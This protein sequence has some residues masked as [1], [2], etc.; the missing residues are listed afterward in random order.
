MNQK[1][2]IAIHGGAG[3]LNKEQMTDEMKDDYKRGLE[4][5]LNAGLAVLRKGGT[6]LLAVEEAVVSLENNPLFNAGKGS[7]LTAQRTY[8]MDA[9]IMDG[10][11]LS[12]GA[13]CGVCGI[14]NPVK[15]AR[16][17]MER[18]KYVFLAGK[19]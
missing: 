9:A 1:I 11:D 17:V 14:K 16:R 10:R 4:E 3:T 7:V 8:E 19:G 15:L 18:S 13:L 12:A 6:A 5:A 2:A